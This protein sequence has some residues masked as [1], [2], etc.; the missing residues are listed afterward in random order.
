MGGLVSPAC[1]LGP[2]ARVTCLRS[3]P[4][5]STHP[6]SLPRPGTASLPPACLGSSLPSSPGPGDAVQQRSG[7]A[8]LD[9]LDHGPARP[10]LPSPNAG[11]CNPPITAQPVGTATAGEWPWPG[12]RGEQR[13]GQGGVMGLTHALSPW[14]AHPA[15]PG[16]LALSGLVSRCS[17]R[18]GSQS[19]SWSC[20]CRTDGSGMRE[21]RRW[22][23]GE[24]AVGHG[25]DGSGMQER[26]WWNATVPSPGHCRRGGKGAEIFLLLQSKSR[27][28]PSCRAVGEEPLMVGSTFGI[29]PGCRDHGDEGKQAGAVPG[30]T[31]WPRPRQE[32][33][34]APGRFEEVELPSASF[35]PSKHIWSW[36]EK[37]S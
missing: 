37:P 35:T 33:Q 12:P 15:L 20:C 4:A 6:C 13:E 18:C 8:G 10:Q 16:A 32:T 25:R 28:A 1:L 22:D 27:L 36:A 2:V 3:S 17:Y 26:W 23:A 19:G 29:H 9:T 30:P 21:S 11:S 24:M 31:A 5:P 7:E 34:G 14:A